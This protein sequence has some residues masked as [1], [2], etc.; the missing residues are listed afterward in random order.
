MLGPG[1]LANKEVAW[2]YIY[3][4]AVCREVPDH[5]APSAHIMGQLIEWFTGK[6]GQESPLLV[7]LRDGSFFQGMPTELMMQIDRPGVAKFLV[8]HQITTRVVPLYEIVSLQET[9]P[10]VPVLAGS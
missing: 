10:R 3:P 4:A 8:D 1:W 5:P 7:L 9:A 2:A 6:T